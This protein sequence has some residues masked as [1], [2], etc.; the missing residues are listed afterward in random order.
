MWCFLV[1]EIATFV[2]GI[3]ALVKGKI[4]F[5]KNLVV[6]GAMARMIGVVLMLPLPLTFSITFAIGFVMAANGRSQHEIAVRAA[7]IATIVEF[8]VF[9]ACALLAVILGAIAPKRPAKRKLPE[10]FEDESYPSDAPDDRGIRPPV[11]GT[12]VGIQASPPPLG[13]PQTK[14]NAGD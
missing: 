12:E 14:T 3:V 6:R 11:P 13:R 4:A 9:I 10:D 7:R 2:M 1:L 5:T 8:G